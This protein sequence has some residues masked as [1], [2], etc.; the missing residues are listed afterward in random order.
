MTLKEKL[1]SEIIAAPVMDE[2]IEYW[3][4]K[5]EQVA[6]DFAIGFAQW[7][8]TNFNK[9]KDNTYYANTSSRYFDI[10]KYVGKEKPTVYCTI[11]SL[12]EIYKKE[13]GL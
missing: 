11:Q 1:K 13:K 12:M 10:T 7:K 4:S 5:L 2:A 9:Y 3:T 6:D 8:D